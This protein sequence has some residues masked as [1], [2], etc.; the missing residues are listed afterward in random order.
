[1][2]GMGFVCH[3]PSDK[4]V[5]MNRENISFVCRMPPDRIHISM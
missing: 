2:C 3:P 1:M 5:F 4:P